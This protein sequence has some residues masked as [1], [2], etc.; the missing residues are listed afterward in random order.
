M[1][2]LPGANIP[3]WGAY[4]RALQK[5]PIK[6]KVITASIIMGSSQASSQVVTHGTVNNKQLLLAWAIWAMPS[7]A[8][9]HFFN[10]WMMKHHANKPLIVKLA[11]DHLLY[12]IAIMF[13]F[14]YYNKIWLAGAT[15]LGFA[16]AWRETLKVQPGMQKT[17]AKLWPTLMTLNYMV[18]PLPLRVLY[19]NCCQFCWGLYLALLYRKP[20]KQLA[21]KETEKAK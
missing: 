20:K 3:I 10:N 9:S 17:S 11:L 14:T 13:V 7:S 21:D 15:N 1:A 4:L 12:R 18:V 6:V 19:L 16:D 2:D 5:D 8:G